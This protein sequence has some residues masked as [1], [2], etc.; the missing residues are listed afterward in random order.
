MASRSALPLEIYCLDRLSHGRGM[1]QARLH[2]SV[3]DVTLTLPVC[4]EW[5]MSI[6]DGI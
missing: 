2:L 4:A 6:V 3:K 1:S 5:L